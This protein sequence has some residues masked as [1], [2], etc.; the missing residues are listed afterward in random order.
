MLA[1]RA[2][3][4]TL[5]RGPLFPMRILRTSL[6][7]LATFAVLSSLNAQ[8]VTTDPVGFTTKIV[9]AATSSTSPTSDVVSSPLYTIPLY[10]GTVGSLDNSTSF[11]FSNAAFA[12]QSSFR[13]LHIL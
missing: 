12:A 13:I 4:F 11:T 6:F 9:A 7:A 1:L 3:P 5:G 8:S 10:K 2:L